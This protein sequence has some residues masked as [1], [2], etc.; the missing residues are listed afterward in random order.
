VAASDRG[1]RAAQPEV[2]SS[3]AALETATTVRAVRTLRVR[4]GRTVTPLVD[5]ERAPPGA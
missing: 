1:K 2:S 4:A 5:E 3:N